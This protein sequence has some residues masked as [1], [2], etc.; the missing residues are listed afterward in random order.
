M[1][2]SN[3]FNKLMFT[4]KKEVVLLSSISNI[5]L[6][7][8]SQI[9]SSIQIIKVESLNPCPFVPGQL[10]IERTCTVWVLFLIIL[11]HQ[12][13]ISICPQTFKP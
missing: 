9:E 2:F 12:K 3:H 1:L 13:K 5:F 10:H 4:L 6:I 8:L 11:K 7:F